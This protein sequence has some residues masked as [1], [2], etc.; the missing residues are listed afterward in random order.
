MV[1]VITIMVIHILIKINEP[2]KG[3]FAPSHFFLT[4][5]CNNLSNNKR[6]EYDASR[7]EY[8]CQY[9]ISTIRFSKFYIFT[10]LGNGY[11]INS[12]E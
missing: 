7:Q 11:V 1:M 12:D 3:A 2:L 10:L 5:L 9:F 6:G 8:P 4:L